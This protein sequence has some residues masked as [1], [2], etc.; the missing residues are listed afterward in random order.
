MPLT[1]HASMVLSYPS[2]A[3]HS[4]VFSSM[5]I[6]RW[7]RRPQLHWITFKGTSR[8]FS[9]VTLTALAAQTFGLISL[10][11]FI[12]I[13]LKTMTSSS[14][15]VANR[16]RD[17]YG[18]IN[19]YYRFSVDRCLDDVTLGDWENASTISGQPLPLVASIST[20]LF[21]LQSH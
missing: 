3:I 17:K 9:V 8:W 14:T 10:L 16:L 21:R 15:E 13:A 1:S 20:Q 11:L 5:Q 19:S 6:W 7:S 4:T 2:F 12:L 18:N